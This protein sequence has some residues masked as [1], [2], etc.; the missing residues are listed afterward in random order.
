[1]R[2]LSAGLTKRQIYHIMTSMDAEFD[3]S[4]HFSEF[5]EFWLVVFTQ[6]LAKHQSN[7]RRKRDTARFGSRE[8][9]AL[10]DEELALEQAS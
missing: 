7:L 5:M 9:R 6:Y 10:P 2:A 8:E 3:R 1:M 4:I